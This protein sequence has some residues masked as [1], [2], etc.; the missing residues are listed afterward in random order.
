MGRAHIHR[1]GNAVVGHIYAR[2]VLIVLV[3]GTHVAP[4][5]QLEEEVEA[6]DR[7]VRG[8]GCEGGYEG[9]AGGAAHAAL[10][11]AA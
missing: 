7:V 1:C 10:W 6:R 9:G 2:L 4:E 5:S 11:P 3:E 8:G